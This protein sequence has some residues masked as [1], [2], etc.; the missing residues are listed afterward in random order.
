[1]YLLHQYWEILSV[2]LICFIHLKV[3]FQNLLINEPPC[4]DLPLL[5]QQKKQLVKWTKFASKPWASVGQSLHPVSVLL[6]GWESMMP[7]PP[8]PPPRWDTSPLQVNFQH[9]PLPILSIVFEMG[10]YSSSGLSM[11]TTHSIKGQ[12]WDLNNKPSGV[13]PMPTTNVFWF[14]IINTNILTNY[15]FLVTWLTNLLGGMFVGQAFF[16]PTLC[17]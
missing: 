15:E 9:I 13:G 5:P 4:S 10:Q 2:F 8:P 11:N 14:K 12:Q 16:A 7:L 17:C 1:M 6:S 3:F